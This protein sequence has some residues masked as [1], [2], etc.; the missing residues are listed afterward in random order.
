MSIMFII[1]TQVFTANSDQDTVVRNTLP[2][3]V[4]CR[5][6]RL[7][8]VTWN[9]H[10]SLRMELYGTGPVQGMNGFKILSFCPGNRM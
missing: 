9:G 8:P 6:L 10:I 2:A 7:L 1:F 4:V 3:P 5:Y